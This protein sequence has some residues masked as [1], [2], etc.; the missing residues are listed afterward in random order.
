MQNQ[1]NKDIIDKLDIIIGLLA[2]QG[3]EKE[4]QIKI[5][6]SLKFSSLQIES[7]TGIPSRTVRDIL[8][9][10]NKLKRSKK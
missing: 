2:S 4:V 7:L 10:K 5:L 3:K 6:N 1:D 8:L 9:K